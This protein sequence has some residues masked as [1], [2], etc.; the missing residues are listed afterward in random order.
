MLKRFNNI[1]TKESFALVQWK[2]GRT[3]VK[4]TE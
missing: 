4:N 2:I 1:L 3:K